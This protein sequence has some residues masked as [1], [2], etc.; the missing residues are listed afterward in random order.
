MKHRFSAYFACITLGVGLATSS[1][2]QVDEHAMSEIRAYCAS[3]I[4]AGTEESEAK[5]I[6]DACIN[7]QSQYLP[8]A[9]LTGEELAYQD[10]AYSYEQDA[11]DA[12]YAPDCYQAADE[13]VQAQLEEDPEAVIDY[14]ALVNDCLQYK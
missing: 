2:A 13:Q 4:Q 14:E 5:Q 12:H 9:S 10:D 3:L 6:I 8:D 11:V 7:E 1:H